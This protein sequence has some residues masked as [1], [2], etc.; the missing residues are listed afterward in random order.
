MLEGAITQ[1]VYTKRYERLVKE[2]Y[3]LKEEADQKAR[4]KQYRKEREIEKKRKTSNQPNRQKQS[5]LFSP[6][7]NAK[8]FSEKKRIEARIMSSND[9]KMKQ[10]K[11]YE[12]ISR[13]PGMMTSGSLNHLS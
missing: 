3:L 13:A 10:L 6:P 12:A 11:S 9:R 8:K 2:K 7:G 1:H 5:I 4:S